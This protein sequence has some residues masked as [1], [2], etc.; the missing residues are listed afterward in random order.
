[1]L[2]WELVVGFEG[3]GKEK[4]VCF[5]VLQIQAM[6]V[7]SHKPELEPKRNVTPYETLFYLTFDGT[8]S[9]DCETIPVSFSSQHIL[10]IHVFPPTVV[11]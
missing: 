9:W 2:G 1:M 5:V 3:E 6:S 7:T 11:F 4:Q 10:V 8:T